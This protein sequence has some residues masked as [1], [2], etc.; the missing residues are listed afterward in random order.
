[1]HKVLQT[2]NYEKQVQ[3]LTVEAVPQGGDVAIEVNGGMVAWLRV[4]EGN[5][6]ELHI[7]RTWC[8]ETPDPR[9]FQV[10]R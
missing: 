9:V 6:V 2:K 4:E 10:V 7:A 8:R 3:I 1:M 5:E